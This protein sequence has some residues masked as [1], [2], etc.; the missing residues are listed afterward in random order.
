MAG[1][2]GYDVMNE[3]DL[4]LSEYFDFFDADDIR[5]K[6]TRIGVETV[7]DDY[8]NAVSPEEIA[9]GYPTLNLE[10][11]YATITFY[12]HHQKEIDQYLERWRKYTEESWKQQEQHPSPTVER[13]QRIKRQ[14]LKQSQKAAA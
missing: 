9:I 13:L 8:L 11:I 10:Q 2:K 4:M 14:R 1:D 5:I 6:G 12:L 3:K 7:L